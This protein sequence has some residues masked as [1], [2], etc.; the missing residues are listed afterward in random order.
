LSPEVYVGLNLLFTFIGAFIL[1]KMSR[2]VNRILATS[3]VILNNQM[4][5]Q[6]GINDLAI[7]KKKVLE[8]QTEFVDKWDY[9][10]RKWTNRQAK[11][12]ERDDDNESEEIK[13]PI[14]GM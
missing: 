12:K 11:R 4:Q 10:M 2:Y 5:L 8:L 6:D 3:D 1:F 14:A 7:T 13:S 9:A